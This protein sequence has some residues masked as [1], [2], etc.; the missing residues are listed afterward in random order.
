MPFFQYRTLTPGN[1]DFKVKSPGSFASE[2]ELPPNVKNPRPSPGL[3]FKQNSFKRLFRSSS[4][5]CEETC[6]GDPAEEIAELKSKGIQ[7]MLN[8]N[9]HRHGADGS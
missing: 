9:S 7:V 4:A 3:E 2:K 1:P 8:L 6:E 5:I